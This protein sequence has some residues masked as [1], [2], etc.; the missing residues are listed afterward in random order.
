[1]KKTILCILS[2]LPLTAVADVTLPKVITSNMVLQRDAPITIW[3]WADV[4]EKVTVTLGPLSDPT[5]ATAET[6]VEGNWKVTLPKRGLGEALSLTVEGRNKISLNNILMGDVWLCS[7]QSNME[8]GISRSENPKEAIA[9][10]N[11]PNIRLFDV[12]KVASKT[13]LKD[14]AK[15]SG[16][17]VCTPESM[18]KT[19]TSGGF[20]AVAYYFGKY[21]QEEMK[22]VPIGLLDSSWGG[23]KIEPW[24]TAAGWASVPQ[25]ADEYNR[26]KGIDPK[27]V[28]TNNQSKSA[29]LYNGM[30]HGLSPLQIKGTLWYQGES[31]RAEGPHYHYRKLALVNGWRKI[32]GEDMPFYFVQLAPFGYPKDKNPEIL[33]IFWQAQQR[34]AEEIPNTGMAVTIDVGNPKNIHP[35]QKA[36]VGKRLALLALKH[37]YD[38]GVLADSPTYLSHEI[39]SGKVTVKFQN[40]GGGLVA[41]DGNVLRGFELAGADGQFVPATEVSISADSV[42]LSNPKLPAPTKVRYAWSNTPNVNLASK[43]G[44]PVPAFQSK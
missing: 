8:W 31:N 23:S 15:G 22:D 19:G 13:P 43:E 18:A 5:T 12:G 30:V 4:G 3:G 37:T 26:I 16:W 14:I 6:D 29:A 25:L 10:A 44:L 27:K 36:Q 24:T 32:W 38:K 41:S 11:H 42:I 7:G 40:T 2:S 21:L 1:M 20:S 33:P 28:K 39:K 9:A 17:K 35:L 34:S